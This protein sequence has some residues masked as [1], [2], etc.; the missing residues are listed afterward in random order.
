MIDTHCHLTYDG[1]IERVDA[2]IAAAHAAGV[3]R[4]ISVGT[5]PDDARQAVALAE[6]YDSI[7]ATVGLHP[8]HAA[9]WADLAIVQNAMRQLSKHPRV[10]ALGEMGLDRH[11]PDPP[12]QTQRAALAAQLQ[13]AGESD[14]PIIIHN[15]QATVDTLA[16]LRASRLPPQRFVFHCFTGEAVELDAILDF[17]AMVSFTGITTFKNARHLADA[18]ARVPLER[19]M[20]ETDSPYLTPEPHRKVRTNEPRYVADVARFI[21][22][23]RSIPLEEFVAAMDANA[24]RFFR[25]P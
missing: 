25:L 4:M 24:V 19:M 13:V 18:A 2:V 23:Q 12:I 20:I 17:G 7:F 16:I 15:R 22:Q 11:Y 6:Q 10:V 14:L 3:E 9:Q 21:A 1:L 8:H 5:S